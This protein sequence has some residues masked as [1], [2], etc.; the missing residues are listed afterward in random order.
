MLPVVTELTSTLA[1]V[2]VIVPLSTVIDPETC[3][4]TPESVTLVPPRS[5]PTEYPAHDSA[6]SA[7]EPER[8]G[9]SVSVLAEP[10]VI[11]GSALGEVVTVPSDAVPS[12]PVRDSMGIA[13][14]ATIPSDTATAPTHRA[15]LSKRLIVESS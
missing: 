3:D 4:V 11:I 5:A 2:A 12:A 9:G 6:E 1:S 14:A 7:Q 10:S 15:A 13:T 8:P